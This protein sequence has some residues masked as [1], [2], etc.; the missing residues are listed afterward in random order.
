MTSSKKAGFDD[1]FEKHPYLAAGMR[2][3]AIGGGAGALAM[4][5]K[6]ILDA[7]KDRKKE[8]KRKNPGVSGD[9]IVITVPKG[10]EVRASA[11]TSVVDFSSGKDGTTHW[12]QAR[13]SDG[14]FA[15][16]W[17]LSVSSDNED[18]EDDDSKVHKLYVEKTSSSKNDNKDGKSEKYNSGKGQKG[19]T[20][21]YTKSV[22]GLSDVFHGFHV[23]ENSLPRKTFFGETGDKSLSLALGVGGAGLGLYLATKTHDYLK[24]KRLKRE[25]EA[26]QQEYVDFLTKKSSTIPKNQFEPS[27]LERAVIGGAKIA[28]QVIDTDKVR[29]AGTSTLGAAGGIAILIAAAST[30]LTKKFL[31]KK[32]EE[33]DEATTARNV[34]KV[35]N[36]VF[37]SASADRP[38]VKTDPAAAL[39]LVKIASALMECSAHMTKEAAEPETAQQTTAPTP[40]KLPS[41]GKADP[42]PAGQSTGSPAINAA[43]RFAYKMLPQAAKAINSIPSNQPVMDWMNDPNNTEAAVQMF[44]QLGYTPDPMFK[45]LPV[46]QQVYGTEA[47]NHR[48]DPL[49]ALS[50]AIDRMG[51]N[52]EDPSQST[53]TGEVKGVDPRVAYALYSDI[54]SR[55]DLYAKAMS[56]PSLK[57]AREYIA[58][59]TAQNWYDEHIKDTWAEKIGLGTPIQWLMNL[60]S[61]MVANTEWGQRLM[62]AQFA[63]RMKEYGKS[64]IPQEQDNSPSGASFDGAASVN[65]VNP[66]G[67]KVVHAEYIEK[68]AEGEED[69]LFGLRGLKKALKPAVVDPS[70]PMSV[71][72]AKLPEIGFLD[73]VGNSVFEHMTDSG[74]EQVRETMPKRVD[75]FY[76]EEDPI[77]SAG[78]TRY[79]SLDTDTL[80]GNPDIRSY[81]DLVSKVRSGNSSA[82]V[83]PGESFYLEKNYPQDLAKLNAAYDMFS[84]PTEGTLGRFLNPN[85]PVF[86][87]DPTGKATETVRDSAG[88]LGNVVSDETQDRLNDNYLAWASTGGENP[89]FTDATGRALR[90]AGL[91]AAM[92]QFDSLQTDQN[93]PVKANAQVDAVQD[94]DSQAAAT[95]KQDERV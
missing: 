93:E 51:V 9:T 5:I 87:Y 72:P 4:A 52:R 49:F 15:P 84:L 65:P 66:A 19:K 86:L 64:V 13:N 57:G 45:D 55:P 37:K 92:R 82:P 71:K 3:T 58:G 94:N 60:F 33:A 39:A 21:S 12:K 73:P 67:Q 11:R 53:Y 42:L 23:D 74:L 69:G 2:G 77:G 35:N 83:L 27:M 68:S 80:E 91:D 43:A 16:G 18:D 24:R 29:N 76:P 75:E 10:K 38:D 25:V 41:A 88:L 47:L 1:I 7:A 70:A 54:E 63:K 46:T 79:D 44:G 56:H 62:S 14:T 59:N 40:T 20:P 85:N 17:E 95:E 6:D 28:P 61:N 89:F 78:A 81:L 22:G 34:P 8:N 36:I 50:M 32:F 48:M 31:D 26:A 90:G 30:F